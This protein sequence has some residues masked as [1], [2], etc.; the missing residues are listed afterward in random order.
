MFLKNQISSYSHT[1]RSEANLA[2]GS[3]TEYLRNGIYWTG[4]QEVTSE[5]CTDRD[6]GR[7]LE[8]MPQELL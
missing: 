5:L 4:I 8:C 3:T 1:Q 6:N 2:F 7:L